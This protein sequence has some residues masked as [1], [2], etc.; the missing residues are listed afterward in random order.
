M[1][2]RS[3]AAASDGNRAGIGKGIRK[4]KGTAESVRGQSGDEAGT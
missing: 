4:K 2:T 3:G 1:K